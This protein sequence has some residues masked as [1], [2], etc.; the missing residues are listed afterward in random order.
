MLHAWLVAGSGMLSNGLAAEEVE[1]EGAEE[2]RDAVLAKQV[3]F[4]ELPDSSREL[5][6]QKLHFSTG[7]AGGLR[8][9]KNKPISTA[10]F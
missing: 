3:E 5:G 1:G 9:K 4:N 10:G 7:G 8:E 2:G 6:F